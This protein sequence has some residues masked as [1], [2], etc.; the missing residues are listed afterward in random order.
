MVILLWILGIYI[1][2]IFLTRYLN[3]VITKIEGINETPPY[4][5]WFIPVLGPLFALVVLV[6]IYF[7][8]RQPGW[9]RWFKGEHWNNKK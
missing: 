8:N 1:G 2:G 9:L 6:I 7:E 5:M 3:F 4:G